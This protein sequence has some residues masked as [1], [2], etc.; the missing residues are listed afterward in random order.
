MRIKRKGEQIAELID[1]F[2]DVYEMNIKHT[3][4]LK[5]NEKLVNN[6]H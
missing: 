6:I 4:I 2:D 5:R 3:C 1:L